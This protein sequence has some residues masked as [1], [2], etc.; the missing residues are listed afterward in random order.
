MKLFFNLQI[1]GKTQK[2]LK[3][4]GR[5]FVGNEKFINFEIHEPLMT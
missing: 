3:I 1:L 5:D 4:C 2:L